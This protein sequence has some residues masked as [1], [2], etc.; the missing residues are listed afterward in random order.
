MVSFRLNIADCFV[1]S[2][3]NSGG[4][5]ILF[6]KENILGKIIAVNFQ[7]VLKL[8][9]WNSVFAIKKASSWDM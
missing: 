5:I 2:E 3:T 4:G 6:V 9:A 8:F 1:R 7:L